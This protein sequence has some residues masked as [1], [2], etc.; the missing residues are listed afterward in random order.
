MTNETPLT[1]SQRQ[2]AFRAKKDAVAAFNATEVLRLTKENEELKGQLKRAV[3]ASQRAKVQH[4]ANVA[5]LRGQ[6]L[7]AIAKTV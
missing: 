7:K 3:E 6:L 5:K 2:A 1:N 4:T